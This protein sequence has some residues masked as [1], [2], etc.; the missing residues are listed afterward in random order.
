MRALAR[1]FVRRPV[2][3]S[4][5]ALAWLLCGALALRLMPVAPLPQVDMPV[6]EV[7]AALPG[8]SPETMARMVSAPLERALGSVAG[9]AE[10]SASTSQGAARVRLTFEFDRDIDDA[11]RDVQAAINAAIGDL[12]AGMPGAPVYRKVNSAQA[13]I[14]VLALSSANLAPGRLYDLAST[15][16]AQK[17]AQ[18]PGVGE[19]TVGGSALPAVRVQL[20]PASLESHGI[21]LD[22]VRRAIGDAD[23]QLPLGAIEDGGL[24][25]QV[26]AGPDLRVAADFEQLV[27]RHD[28]GAMLRL[29]D[30]ARVSDGV[31]N[32]YASGHHNRDPAVLLTVGR[33]PGANIVAT[34]DTIRSQMPTLTALLPAD[35]TL[36]VVVDRSPGIRASL[37]EAWATLWIAGTLVVLVVWAFLG[38]LRAAL[39]PALAVPVSLL[40]ACALMYLAGFSLNNLSLMA[41]IVAAGLVVDDAIV[42][43]ENIERHIAAGMRPYRAAIVGLGEVGFTLLAMNLALIAVFASILFMGGV[44][45]RLFREFSLTLVMAMTV[46]LMVS[47]TLAPALSGQM[48]LR[49]SAHPPGLLRRL[50]SLVFGRLEAVYARTLDWALAHAWVVLLVL[51]VAVGLT[52]WLY[53]L[54]PR[55]MLPEQDTGQLRGLVRGDDGFSFQVM[56]P[57]IERFREYL[58]ADP[59]V[60]DVIITS[61]GSGGGMSNGWLMVRLKPL[62]LRGESARAALERIR[63]NAPREPGAILLLN[64]DQDLQLSAPFGG[65]GEELLLLG[66]DLARLTQWMRKVADGMRT[67]PEVA[68]VDDFG[69]DATQIVVIDIDRE[70]AARLGVDA[71]LVTSL[72]NNAF[73]QR[74][75]ATLFGRLNQ[76]RVVMELEPG[77]TAD[78]SVLDRL[79]VVTGDGQRVPLSAFVSYRYELS[80]DRVFRADQFAVVGVEYDLAPGVTASEAQQAINGL[81][82]RLMLPND[83]IAKPG[84][85][86]S[87]LQQTMQAQPWLI[88]WVVVA[89]YVVLGVLYE[90][91][92][93]P[94]T[95]LSTLPPAG[96]GALAALHLAG[97][98]FSLIALLGLF[99]LIGVVMKNAILMI[100]FALDGER[101][102][103]LEPR[104]SIRRAASLRLRPILMTN[105]AAVLA[106]LPLAFGV[107]EGAEL[108]RPLGIA[109]VG[110][111]AVSQLLTLYTTP[112]VYLVLDRMRTGFTT[113]RGGP[114]AAMR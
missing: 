10:M 92:L 47:L 57:K 100:D 75:V 69:N 16:L 89:V 38:S 63:R 51:V 48:L 73:S 21:A 27:L 61:G 42:V 44:V 52:V 17:I 46:S 7:S 102:L 86:G 37:D 80:S 40:G 56:Q 59:A 72:M 91:T 88:L 81:L 28:H 15:I 98:A 50:A 45:E 112:V 8:G 104:S 20:D 74:Q 87:R 71:E 66:D 94:L 95:I 96:V 14:M 83:I 5:L 105:L 111:L 64:I 25:W 97:I 3:A 113:A 84:G 30:V 106:A 39:I 12:P 23:A 31:E 41:L 68:D 54:V 65:R 19:V 70:A 93:H 101:R 58:L 76:Y 11:A 13:P 62:A 18:M 107:G 82:A 77:H 78:A 108:R 110:G 35:T 43:L 85:D 114:A 53:L 109:I 6:I 29:G 55:T 33:Q 9:V 32:R 90:S 99:L 24:R 49:P 2:A 4:L 22:E 1:L 36:D 34:I 60:A 67:L 79:Q 26:G 103:G